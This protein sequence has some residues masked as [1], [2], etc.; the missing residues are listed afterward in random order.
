MQGSPSLSHNRKLILN[1][2]SNQYSMVQI[3]NNNDKVSWDYDLIL[4]S[5]SEN[6]SK[7]NYKICQ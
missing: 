1:Q 4:C 7:I 6:Y 5:N 3:G 2:G